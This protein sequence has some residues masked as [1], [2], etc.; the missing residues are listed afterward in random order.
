M[1]PRL[2]YMSVQHKLE[3]DEWLTISSL[4]HPVELVEQPAKK[5]QEMIVD[6]VQQY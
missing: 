4:Y 1:S 5:L 2:V 3:I 6:F